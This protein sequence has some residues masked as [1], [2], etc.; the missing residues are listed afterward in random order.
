[1]RRRRRRRRR[2]NVGRLPVPEEP[3]CFVVRGGRAL[4][5]THEPRQGAHQPPAHR[6]CQTSL[7]TS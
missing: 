1:M 5:D 6:A 3:P 7:A 2:F 4:H